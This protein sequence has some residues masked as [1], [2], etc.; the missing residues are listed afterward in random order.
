MWHNEST[1]ERGEMKEELIEEL[2]LN[3]DNRSGPP[4]TH[5]EGGNLDITLTTSSL[6]PLLHGWTVDGYTSVSDHRLIVYDV[7][8]SARKSKVDTE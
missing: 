1:N 3:I 8:L 7:Q 4:A 5:Q 2:N 6:S